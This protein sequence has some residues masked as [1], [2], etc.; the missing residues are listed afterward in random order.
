MHT[1]SCLHPALVHSSTDFCHALHAGSG[2]VAATTFRLGSSHLDAKVPH[3]CRGRCTQMRPV[4][5]RA[6]TGHDGCTQTT[7]TAAGQPALSQARGGKGC[8]QDSVATAVE[9]QPTLI[10]ALGHSSCHHKHHWSWRQLQFQLQPSNLWESSTQSSETD[11]PRGSAQ[12]RHPI[13]ITTER[14][15]TET[16]EFAN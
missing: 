1:G 6:S 2:Y 15:P 16:G 4:G 11:G 13:T 8:G 9:Y 5:P 12:Q 10:S 7:T 3:R 14:T